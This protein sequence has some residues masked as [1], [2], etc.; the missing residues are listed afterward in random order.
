MDDILDALAQAFELT[1]EEVREIAL[2]DWC[3]RETAELDV[4]GKRKL[5]P[6]L[7]FIYDD[8]NKLIRGSQ[9]KEILSSDYR[10]ALNRL[11]AQ[12]IFFELYEKD[13]Q[14]PDPE[15]QKVLIER[16]EHPVSKRSPS[17]A[18]FLDDVAAAQGVLFRELVSFGLQ[19]KEALT[20]ATNIGTRTLM[21]S[22]MRDWTKAVFARMI[23]RQ[24]EPNLSE[25]NVLLEDNRDLA[26]W[27]AEEAYPDIQFILYGEHGAAVFAG[28][29]EFAEQWS[30][31]RQPGRKIIV[32]LTSILRSVAIQLLKQGKDPFGILTLTAWKFK[33]EDVIRDL[34]DEQRYA[35][36]M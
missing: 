15:N 7:P 24:Q 8:D 27:K 31:F 11:Q 28:E 30:I 17:D 22:A 12:S 1:L 21:E 3:A 20:L 18:P 32:N 25:K 19:W 9:L 34:I 36:S 23:L 2:A 10:T 13:G 14:I 33:V 16:L 5:L 6:V 29:K 4:Y 35:E 26:S